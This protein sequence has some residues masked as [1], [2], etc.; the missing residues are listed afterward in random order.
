M[1]KAPSSVKKPAEPR[2]AARVP[3]GLR[4]KL[5]KAMKTTNQS[6][7]AFLITALEEFLENH[8]TP[9]DKIGAIIKGHAARAAAK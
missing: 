8:P 6:E 2:V 1:P 4:K 9:A 3:A 5:T 7:T